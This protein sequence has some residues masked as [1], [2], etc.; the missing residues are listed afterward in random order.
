M[1]RTKL[2]LVFKRWNSLDVVSV[3]S[4]G[5][6]WYVIGG[7]LIFSSSLKKTLR[8]SSKPGSIF[9][10]VETVEKWDRFCNARISRDRSRAHFECRPQTFTGNLDQK[11]KTFSMHTNIKRADI[12][13]N[14]FFVWTNRYCRDETRTNW[15]ILRLSSLNNFWKILHSNVQLEK[16][17]SA[18]VIFYSIFAKF[19]LLIHSIN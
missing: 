1:Y 14:S 18:N 12:F 15:P 4:K 6:L 2:N 19:K 10:A 17:S 9:E 5:E 13:P 11:L 3:S 7:N 16:D 8:R